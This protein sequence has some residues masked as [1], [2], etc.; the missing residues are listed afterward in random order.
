MTKRLRQESVRCES[1]LSE[2]VMCDL[3]NGDETTSTGVSDQ[4]M[5]I[6]FYWT[7]H[8]GRRF[9]VTRRLNLSPRYWSEIRPRDV[10]LIIN[11]FQLPKTTWP[12]LK[13]T[14]ELSWLSKPMD[15][16]STAKVI[17]L[18][19]QRFFFFSCSSFTH[20]SRSSGVGN[21]SSSLLQHCFRF[22]PLTKM[23]TQLR[24]VDFGR[25]LLNDC[26]LINKGQFYSTL[27]T[28]R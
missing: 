5:K 3:S 7:R 16:S 24:H 6:D 15:V 18:L 17:P 25:L 1:P 27:C 21:H 20:R 9:E 4:T 13:E 11:H 10:S 2:R 22:A 14:L 28:S 19:W 26:A 12:C 8:D 23:L